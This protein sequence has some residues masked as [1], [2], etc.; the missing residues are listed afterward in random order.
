MKAYLFPL[1]LC[2]TSPAAA[3]PASPVEEAFLSFTS[4][5]M[6]NNANAESVGA[7]LLAAGWSQG[8]VAD[9]PVTSQSR[10]R[11]NTVILENDVTAGAR[12]WF[13]S[14][15]A[16]ALFVTTSS[17]ERKVGKGRARHT[18]AFTMCSFYATG[19]TREAVAGLIFGDR[20]PTQRQSF[21]AFPLAF[22]NA[23]GKPFTFGVTAIDSRDRYARF[24]TLAFFSYE[25]AV[26]P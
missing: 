22:S 26:T 7:Q 15:D 20:A 25:G 24:G 8:T 19:V 21:L 3:Q 1:A 10:R 5:C 11:G 16:H 9:L 14:D 23:N 2:V 6:N 18:E 12:V 13:A 17:G 4:V